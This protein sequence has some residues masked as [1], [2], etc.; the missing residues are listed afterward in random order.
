MP[1]EPRKM[2]RHAD[3]C[4]DELVNKYSLG[5][6]GNTIRFPSMRGKRKLQLKKPIPTANERARAGPEAEEA[7][8]TK[9]VIMETCPVIIRRDD[10]M[11]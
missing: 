11:L 3:G 5:Q 8:R 9:D 4:H 10:D 1:I 7:K 2:E 6:R